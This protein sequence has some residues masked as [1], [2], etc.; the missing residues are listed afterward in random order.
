MLST[1]LTAE[2]VAEGYIRDLVHA[3]QNLRRDRGCEYIDRIEL[4]IVTD[5]DELRRAINEFADYIQSETLSVRI[6]FEPFSDCEPIE[7][8]IADQKV[9]IYLR[10][11]SK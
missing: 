9:L 11:V 7:M 3:I 4:G 8:K 6:V 10:R 1:E 2:L 5:S